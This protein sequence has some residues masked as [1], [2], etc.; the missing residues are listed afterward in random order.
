[1]LRSDRQMPYRVKANTAVQKP[2]AEP[3]GEQHDEADG[4]RRLADVAD[5]HEQRRGPPQPRRVSRDARR[6]AR[7]SST[8]T[9]GDEREAARAAQVRCRSSPTRAGAP[10]SRRGPRSAATTPSH[11]RPGAR[12]RAARSR[13]R[14]CSRD[15][16]R[17]G[18]SF[19]LFREL[20][21]SACSLGVRR[22]LRTPVLGI[23]V[24]A[25]HCRGLLGVVDGRL[26]ICWVT[27]SKSTT[28]RYS[29][30]PAGDDRRRRG[31]RSACRRGRR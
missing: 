18:T 12:G 29:S 27:D 7:C 28:P 16:P 11:R 31:W 1:V 15:R 13:S 17:A 5:A 23:C 14:T 21:S 9:V 8:K 6:D 3:D 20:G 25:V 22:P 26:L 10:R 4:G 19:R 30:A 24:G 2:K